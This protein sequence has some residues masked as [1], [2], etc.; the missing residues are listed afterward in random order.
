MKYLFSKKTIT[1]LCCVI[2]SVSTTACS[3]SLG[4]DEP[5]ASEQESTPVAHVEHSALP[6]HWS[7]TGDTGPENWDELDP[8]NSM[9]TNGKEQSPIDIE[10]SQIKEDSQLTDLMINYTPT[11]ISLMNNGHT[12]QATPSNPNI[13][14]ILDGI[15][16]KLAQFHFHTPSEH[17]FNGENLAME[18]HLVHKDADGQIAVLGLLIKE[19]QENIDLSSIWDLLP[20]EETTADI[21]V[22]EPIDL[23]Q[24]LPTNQETFRYDGSLTTP[25]CTENVKWVILEQPIEMS[26]AQIQKFSSIFP[27]DHRPVQD[28]NGRVISE[29]E[30]H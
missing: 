5:T 15:E 14:I 18:L 6:A 19:G 16:Y 9:C 29:Q 28:L 22:K 24:L 27:D 17:Q 12:I 21:Q 13:S 4:T 25:P 3:R 11:I 20:E 8:K 30:A 1:L 7:Y 26:A 2:V 10:F 23:S